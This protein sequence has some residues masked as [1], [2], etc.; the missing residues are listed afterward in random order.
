MVKNNTKND[1]IFD[2]DLLNDENEDFSDE[3]IKDSI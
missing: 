2:Y 1:L 3:V